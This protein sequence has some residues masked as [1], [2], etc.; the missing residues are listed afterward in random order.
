MVSR[1]SAVLLIIGFYLF[2]QHTNDVFG[3]VIVGSIVIFCWV[4]LWDPI[5]VFLHQYLIQKGI[6][7]IG[8]KRILHCTVRVEKARV[9]PDGMPVPGKIRKENKEINRTR[10][11]V[12]C[13]GVS[14][15]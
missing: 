4:A 5:D 15:V 6:I 7:R 11:F 14:P 2:S 8:E 1:L 12:P 9:G 3:Q 13:S 10:I